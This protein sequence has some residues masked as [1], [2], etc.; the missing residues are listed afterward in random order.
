MRCCISQ[1]SRQNVVK[2]LLWLSTAKVFS[3]SLYIWKFGSEVYTFKTW[4]CLSLSSLYIR[5][6]KKHEQR[7]TKNNK[8]KTFG[9][10]SCMD[11]LMHIECTLNWQ[12]TENSSSNLT[13]WLLCNY[14]GKCYLQLTWLQQQALLKKY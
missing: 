12:E 2:V 13:I 9:L 14:A 3:F 1:K 5:V 10:L 6:K 4:F 11:C 7:K 8:K